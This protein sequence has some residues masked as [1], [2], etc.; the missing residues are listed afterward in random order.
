MNWL[1]RQLKNA[2]DTARV[3]AFVAHARGSGG[4]RA[5]LARS[6]RT[7]PV[8]VADP[9]K[10]IRSFRVATTGTLGTK[11]GRGRGA[12]IDSVLGAVDGF[13]ADVLGSLRAWSAAPPKLRP[14]H[15]EPPRASTTRVPASLASTDYSSQDGPATSEAYG[16]GERAGHVAAAPTPGVLAADEPPA[17]ESEA[18]P[19]GLPTF[20]RVGRPEGAG[21]TDEDHPLPV[22]TIIEIGGELFA[23]V[24]EHQGSCRVRNDRMVNMTHAPVLYALAQ[25][26]LRRDRHRPLRCRQARGITAARP[27]GV[28]S[29]SHPSQVS[30]ECWRPDGVSG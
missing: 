13:Y 28:R 17:T 24:E 15:A 8:L 21:L 25:H 4:G 6:G 1:V 20:G 3:E 9:A 30:L 10:E 5:A 18:P 23:W 22:E 11:R 19:F 16:D 26:C 2:P 14:A 27:V 12:F 7:R 29:N